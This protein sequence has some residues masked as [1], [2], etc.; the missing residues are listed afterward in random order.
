M[1]SG[2]LVLLQLLGSVHRNIFQTKPSKIVLEV[3]NNYDC[4]KKSQ[5]AW[6]MHFFIVGYT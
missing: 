4:L 1:C 3:L 5:D 6:K 2:S